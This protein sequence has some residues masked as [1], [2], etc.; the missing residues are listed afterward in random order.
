MMSRPRL[1]FYRV[2]GQYRPT[3]SFT[4]GVN[5]FRMGEV[6]TF[7][8]ES[9]RGGE[10]ST[11]YVFRD[12]AGT[13]RTFDVPD[14]MSTMALCQRFRA[15]EAHDGGCP[16][17]RDQRVRG[18][19]PPLEQVGHGHGPILYYQCRQCMSLWEET[20]RE[21]H[22]VWDRL[23]T[24]AHLNALERDLRTSGVRIELETKDWNDKGAGFWVYFRAGIERDA[25][26]ARFVFPAFVE[27]HEWDG[28]VGGQEAGFSCTR[29]KS[30]VMG[31][32]P[33]YWDGLPRFPAKMEVPP[34]FVRPTSPSSSS[35][36]SGASRSVPR[37][38]LR[39]LAPLLTFLVLFF[40][41][42]AAAWWAGKR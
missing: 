36:R 38:L 25:T 16:E 28:R 10:A 18:L 23:L 27:W 1:A 42:I 21:A 13:I 7:V 3:S 12:V 11:S 14:D 24:C 5:T 32:H 31:M 41:A 35:S 2:G 29:C 9:R 4:D 40:G 19:G 37:T 39:D 26:R 30:G 22:I 34:R 17:C 33:N 8:I 15:V 20:T 6:L